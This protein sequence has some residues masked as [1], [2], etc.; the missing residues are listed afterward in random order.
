MIDDSGIGK[1]TVMPQMERVSTGLSTGT[2]E[3]SIK[4]QVC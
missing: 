3:V 1:E 2:E 4:T